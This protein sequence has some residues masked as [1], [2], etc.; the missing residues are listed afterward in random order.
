MKSWKHP[1]PQLTRVDAF[2]RHVNHKY[3]LSL[4]D[5]AQLHKWSVDKIEDFGRE[6]WT[7][8]GLVYSIPPQKV[9]DGLDKM[10]PRP[11]WFPGAR[12]NYAENLLAVGLATHPD[13][14]AVA[15]IREGGSQYRCLTWRQLRDAVGLYATAL[16]S[17]GV[18]QGDRVASTCVI[19][20][21][22][23][24]PGAWTDHR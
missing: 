21:L 24:F 14:I 9:G 13:A 23:P 10:W 15:A 20:I 16:R 3:G 1:S 18:Q 19:I 7:F 4:S 2:R 5:Y 17:T 6:A 8:C 11:T 22:A 12:L